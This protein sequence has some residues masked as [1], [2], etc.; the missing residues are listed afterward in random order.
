MQAARHKPC[1][2]PLWPQVDCEGQELLLVQVSTQYPPLKLVLQ[3]PD[4]HWLD[5]VQAPPMAF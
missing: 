5:S 3:F 2:V 4:R 1:P